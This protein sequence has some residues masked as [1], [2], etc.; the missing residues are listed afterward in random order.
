M[1][2]EVRGMGIRVAQKVMV[3]VLL[4]Y[5][6]LIFHRLFSAFSKGQ[7]SSS[8]RTVNLA[9]QHLVGYPVR[10]N[11][12]HRKYLESA[13]PEDFHEVYNFLISA[14]SRPNSAVGGNLQ[15][16]EKIGPNVP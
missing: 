13:S 11:S 8:V 15:G 14:A 3:R 12:Q 2:G 16:V 10:E 7:V 5:Q 6:S 1:T 9:V 4:L